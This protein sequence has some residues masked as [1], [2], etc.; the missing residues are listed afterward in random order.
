M[1]E[2]DKRKAIVPD[3]VSGYILKESIQEIAKPIYDIIEYSL[4]TEKV[5]KEFKRANI[6]PIYKSGNKKESL[7]Y[8]PVLLTTIFLKLCEKVIKKQL[9]EF[10]EREGIITDR[11]FGFRTE[12][13]CVTNLLSFYSRV[14]DINQERDGL[15]LFKIKKDIW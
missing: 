7:N 8:W 4:K 9:M 5:S 10:L 3:L 13:S 1:K 15:H 2:L 6:I 14:V 11:Q 12:K